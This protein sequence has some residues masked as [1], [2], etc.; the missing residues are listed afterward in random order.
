MI[1]LLLSIFCNALLFIIIKYFEKF[2]INNLQAIVTN[3]LCACALGLMNNH[4]SLPLTSVPS[5]P[6]APVA[7]LLGALFIIVFTLIAKTAQEVGVSVATVSN[8]MSV[9]IPVTIAILAYHNSFG[10]LKALGIMTALVAV[11]MTSKKRMDTD[12][13][14]TSNTFLLILPLIVFLGSGIADAFVNYAQ[15]KLVPKEESSLFVATFF[16]VAGAIGLLWVM[17]ELYIKKEK[18]TIRNIIGGI[19]LGIPNYFSIYF[20]I[21]ALNTHIYESS[22]LYPINNMG[23]VILS[24]TGGYFLLKEKLSPLNIGGIVLSIISIALIAFS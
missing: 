6:W 7:V 22:V 3:Y 10:M 2:R 19:A 14:K 4:T 12:H 23:I 15:E 9:I 20:M 17:S 5:A 24:A 13:P 11:Y 1:Y 16:A 18:V 21:K 8:K